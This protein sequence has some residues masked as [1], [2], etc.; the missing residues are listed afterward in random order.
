MTA[1][2]V[3]PHRASVFVAAAALPIA[4]MGLVQHPC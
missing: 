2:E 4:A 3:S 1:S